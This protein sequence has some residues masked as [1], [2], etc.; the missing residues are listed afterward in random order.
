MKT[1]KVFTFG[2]VIFICI[3][4]LEYLDG[5]IYN[6][7]LNEKVDINKIDFSEDLSHIDGVVTESG[8]YKEKG[9]IAHG[10]GGLDNLTYTN[11]LESVQKAMETFD[12]IEVDL[13]CTSDNHIVLCHHWG[14]E[15]G[16]LSYSEFMSK[17]IFDQYTPI[18]LEMFI[19]L[20]KS[21]EKRIILD[22]RFTNKEQVNIFINELENC[23]DVEYMKENVAIIINDIS[24]LETL[25]DKS[26]LNW[27]YRMSINERL[28]DTITLCL[29]NNI[30]AVCIEPG[31]I[32]D[33]DLDKLNCFE[34]FNI[35]CLIYK[36]NDIE[37]AFSFWDKG[38][39]Y[40]FTD[41]IIE[42]ELERMSKN[43]N[44]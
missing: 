10:G 8:F 43:N 13:L 40:I 18:D 36:T 39:K 25:G 22:G 17:K 23:C 34:D 9:L 24:I 28:S 1:K 19:K 26:G 29:Q 4:C 33:D 3:L 2:I 21:S 20:V 37:V 15:K 35:N 7:N 16:A 27:I 30:E 41:F 6:K 5:L 44:A 12:Y 14:E 42:E 11:S 32:D 31:F 38:I